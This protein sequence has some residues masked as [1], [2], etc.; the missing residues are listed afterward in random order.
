[1]EIETKSLRPGM[2]LLNDVNGVSGKPIVEKN[3]VLTQLEIEFIQKF[4]IET[5]NVSLTKH[6]R[7]KPSLEPSEEKIS[8]QEQKEADLDPLLSTYR[9]EE[10]R[11]GKEDIVQYTKSKRDWSSDVCSSDLIW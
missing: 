8:L 7:V 9:S 11:V 2:V 1:M 3:T 5:V 6:E 4:L 10:R